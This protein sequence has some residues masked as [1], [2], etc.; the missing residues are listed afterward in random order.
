MSTLSISIEHWAAWI[1]GISERSDWQLW[2]Q[3]LKQPEMGALPNL[4][5]IPPMLRRRLSSVGK[6]AL[7]VA[8]SVIPSADVKLPVVFASRHG[9]LERTVTMLK[10]LANTESNTQATLSPTQFS[11]SVH[12]AISGVY[13]IA[14]KDFSAITALAI[15]EEGINVALTE[16]ELIMRESDSDTILCVIYD[17]PLPA[18][19][20]QNDAGPQYPYALAIKLCRD[21]LDDNA[22]KLTLTLC[23][24]SGTEQKQEEPQALRF[25]R[26]LLNAHQQELQ[27]PGLQQDWC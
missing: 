6:M 3:G 13:S 9:E 24:R 8:W 15:G 18:P 25:V 16:A 2:Q 14:R 17:E 21:G 22:T 26:Y 11:L 10:E 23:E 20:R 5:Q 4:V 1:P 12:N 7:S 27:L 19:Y